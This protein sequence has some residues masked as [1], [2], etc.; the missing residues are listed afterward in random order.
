MAERDAVT[1]IESVYEAFGRGDIPYILGLLHPEVAWHTPSSVPFSKGLY[2][3]PDEVGEFFRAM[4]ANVTEPGVEVD[5]VFPAGDRV[6]ALIRFRGRGRGS[7]RPFE[8]AEAHLWR[9]SGGE[10]VELRSYP[11]SAAVLLGLQPSAAT[12]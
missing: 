10:V 4:A 8:A 7:G 3:G 1:T 11:D 6:V 9:L 2:R 12:A 5:E